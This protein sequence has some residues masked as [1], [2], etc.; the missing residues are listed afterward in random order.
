MRIRK[1]RR[2]ENA[3]EKDKDKDKVKDKGKVED[4]NES[5]DKWKARQDKT[6]PPAKDKIR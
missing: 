6:Q 5:E 1:V 2:E 4:K 3:T